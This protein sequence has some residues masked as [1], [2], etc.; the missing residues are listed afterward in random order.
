MLKRKSTMS[1]IRKGKH[2]ED[3]VRILGGLS[4]D[5]MEKN[6]YNGIYSEILI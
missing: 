3:S 4:K 2:G 6:I 1:V 5:Q